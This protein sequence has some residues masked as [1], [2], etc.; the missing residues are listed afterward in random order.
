MQALEWFSE[1]DVLVAEY[2][3]VEYSKRTVYLL[4]N[5][6]VLGGAEESSTDLSRNSGRK[7]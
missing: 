4:A 1:E 7:R 3:R 6:E 5:G 2:W